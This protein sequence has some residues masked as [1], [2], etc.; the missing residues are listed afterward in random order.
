MDI[1]NAPMRAE[2]NEP[3]VGERCAEKQILWFQ[4]VARRCTS[5]RQSCIESVRGGTSN[6]A[7]MDRR[8]ELVFFYRRAVGWLSE[9]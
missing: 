1:E 3:K 5:M 6:L 9:I 7:S 4:I 2:P 8:T